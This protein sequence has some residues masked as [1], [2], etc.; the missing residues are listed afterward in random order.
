[1]TR[2][3]AARGTVI[4]RETA[5]EDA[6]TAPQTMYLVILA[7]VSML[8]IT[9]MRECLRRLYSE[10]VTAAILMYEMNSTRDAVT[11][12]SD[13]T[14]PVIPGAFPGEGVTL[15]YFVDQ[16]SHV[17]SVRVSVPASGM[18]LGVGPFPAPSGRTP[19]VPKEVLDLLDGFAIS[20][21]DRLTGKFRDLVKELLRAG[22][23]ADEVHDE[24]RTALAESVM[25]E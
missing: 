21:P 4:A 3:V 8:Y 10:V 16:V 24:V 7:L 25:E 5:T 18:S 2:T 23:A 12:P 1:M 11:G 22:M 20:G 14:I 15:S 13:L 9:G 17:R 19:A 6:R